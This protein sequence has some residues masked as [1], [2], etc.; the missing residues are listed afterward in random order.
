MSKNFGPLADHKLYTNT[1]GKF[2]SF[3]GIPVTGR[4][5]E[6]TKKAMMAPRCG[7]QDIPDN[8]D[9]NTFE[10]QNYVLISMSILKFILC[11]NTVFF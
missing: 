4:L 11:L 5:D 8:F 7:V 1:L 2:Q 9:V 6:E 3:A 10:P